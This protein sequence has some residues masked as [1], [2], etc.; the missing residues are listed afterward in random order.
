MRFITGNP[1]GHKQSLAPAKP[2][3]GA[4]PRVTR[5]GTETQAEALARAEAARQRLIR[6]M[7]RED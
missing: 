5:R 1:Y 6:L 4:I 2:R 7:Q 3:P